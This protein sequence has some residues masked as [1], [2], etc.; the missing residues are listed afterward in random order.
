MKLTKPL[1]QIAVNAGIAISAD[2]TCIDPQDWVDVAELAKFAELIIA[3]CMNT[4]NN[5]QEVPASE[6]RHCA[7]DIQAHFM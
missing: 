4:C 1:H 5:L 7:Q 6:P 2:G 3:E